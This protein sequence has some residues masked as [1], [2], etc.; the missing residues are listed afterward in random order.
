MKARYSLNWQR[1]A[2]ILIH[3]TIAQIKTLQATTRQDTPKRF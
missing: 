3:L 2:V 1:E